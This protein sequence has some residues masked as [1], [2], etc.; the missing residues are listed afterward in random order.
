MKYLVLFALIAGAP[1][2]AGWFKNFC[3]RHL[4]AND[5]DEQPIPVEVLVGWYRG[6]GGRAY[7]S[8]SYNDIRALKSWGELIR[9]R[10]A[11]VDNAY[12]RDALLDALDDYGFLEK[13]V[14]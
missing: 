7:W 9:E 14:K 10:L 12:E 3:E 13:A 1:A 6:I 5:P 2:H 11:T 4:I 8:R